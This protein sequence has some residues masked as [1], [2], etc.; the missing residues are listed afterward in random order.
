MIGMDDDVDRSCP[1]LKRGTH[2]PLALYRPDALELHNGNRTGV[3]ND[4]GSMLT[5]F[6]L[7]PSSNTSAMARLILVYWQR[8]RG[9][10]F[11]SIA[12]NSCAQKPRPT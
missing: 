6:M 11:I 5:K 4:A 3:F 7:T 10:A 9:G 12:I 1:D 2:R 8:S